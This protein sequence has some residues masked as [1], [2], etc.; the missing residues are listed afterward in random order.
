MNQAD[1]PQPA[2]PAS[3]ANPSARAF[4]EAPVPV[5]PS[6]IEDVKHALPNYVSLSLDQGTEILRQ[7]ALKKYAAA[8]QE[9][10]NQVT[11]AQAELSQAAGKSPADQQAAIRHLQQVQ[12]EQTQKLQQIGGELQTQIA[13]L[14]QLK[15]A[16]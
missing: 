9:L 2:P 12:A 11:Q 15:N 10:Q 1:N 16:K 8:A 7:A 5:G 4:V 6:A 3:G 14:K 13:A